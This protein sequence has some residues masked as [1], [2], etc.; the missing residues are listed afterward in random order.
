MLHLD[1]TF[2]LLALHA[3]ESPLFTRKGE[4]ARRRSN[5]FKLREDIKGDGNDGAGRLAGT[6]EAQ[7]WWWWLKGKTLMGF[8]GFNHKSF[9]IQPTPLCILEWRAGQRATHNV[10]T[11]C[12][13]WGWHGWLH[14]ET[15]RRMGGRKEKS[16][17]SCFFSRNNCTDVASRHRSLKCFPIPWNSWRYDEERGGRGVGG[18]RKIERKK[19]NYVCNIEWHY[20]HLF[21]HQNDSDF[22]SHFD[23][24][25]HLML[26]PLLCCFSI[27]FVPH[28][29]RARC[30]CKAA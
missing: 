24:A 19:F 13:W 14:K 30:M 3:P 29:L 2:F 16:E 21:R 11:K 10:I 12:V 17:N 18:K 6:R 26:V 1:A 8:L 9:S 20:K 4:D 15:I 23:F 22:Q 25:V 27:Y 7:W 5:Y 28:C